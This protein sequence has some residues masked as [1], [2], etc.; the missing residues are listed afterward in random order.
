[1]TFTK[2]DY[3]KIE[4]WLQDRSIKDTEFEAAEPLNG[5]EGVPIIQN[6]KNRI[7]DLGVFSK[8]LVDEGIRGFMGKPSG[9]APLDRDS[10]VPASY[11]P[12]YV[13]DVLEFDNITEFPTNGEVGKI[14]V[15][16][17]TNLTYRWSGSGYIE[18]SKSLGLGETSGTAYAGNKGKQNAIDIANHKSSTSNPHNVTK[19]QVG[20]GNVENTSDADKPVSN[21]V[22]VELNRK[23]NT[24]DLMQ[25]NYLKPIIATISEDLDY[26]TKD[27]VGYLKFAD[28]S[29]NNNPNGPTLG[30]K[31][32]RKLDNDTISQ[33]DFDSIN[34]IYE[35]RTSLILNTDI[36]IPS[37]CVLKFNGGILKS[38][39]SIDSFRLIGNNTRIIAG[40]NSKFL[41]CGLAGNFTELKTSWLGD[42]RFKDNSIY[43]TEHLIFDCDVKDLVSPSIATFTERSTFNPK[44]AFAHINYTVEGN[45]FT[46]ARTFTDSSFSPC[47][48]LYCT[49]VFSVRNLNCNC[50][51]LVPNCYLIGSESRVGSGTKHPVK[52]LIDDVHIF[53]YGNGVRTSI[54]LLSSVEHTVEKLVD[55]TNCTCEN[56]AYN[57]KFIYYNNVLLQ[58]ELEVI[59]FQRLFI[60][61][62]SVYRVQIGNENLSLSSDIIDSHTPYCVISNCNFDNSSSSNI[63]INDYTDVIIAGCTGKVNI[64]SDNSYSYLC[65]DVKSVSTIS[66]CNN[67]F[68]GFNITNLK[69]SNPTDGTPITV[70]LQLKGNT[71][72]GYGNLIFN[73]GFKIDVSNNEF[74]FDRKGNKLVCNNIEGNIYNNKFITSNFKCSVFTPSTNSIC[75]ANNEFYDLIKGG[76]SQIAVTDTINNRTYKVDVCAKDWFI[77]E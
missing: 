55:I 43:S 30:Y 2:D 28:R 54:G 5:K 17:D 59:N 46:I 57:N 51:T 68:N 64:K 34:T 74:Y 13:D 15:D 6:G 31:V 25:G 41:D 65:P 32:I 29:P 27:N 7:A 76:S 18:I 22:K 49:G 72:I 14:Y 12:S 75:F 48:L 8:Q 39:R 60:D 3:E 63:I 4:K 70:N 45:N 40:S 47:F 50:G 71:L 44:T 1:M 36:N 35:I 20:L 24:D 26:E 73:E 52:L 23:A 61:N 69:S 67:K 19:S 58:E 62:C 53:P 33:S 66:I 10:K 56:L 37:G 16:T 9:V 11:L 21:A 77:K 42:F 38:N